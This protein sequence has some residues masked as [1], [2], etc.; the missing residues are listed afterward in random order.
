MRLYDKEKVIK[1]LEQAKGNA[2]NF[3][4]DHEHY[5]LD[6]LKAKFYMDNLIIEVNKILEQKE[7][8][9]R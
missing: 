2:M 9:K 5:Q 7:K 3:V 1:I 4:H 6:K 8:E